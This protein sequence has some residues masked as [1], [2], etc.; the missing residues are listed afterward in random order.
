M[1]LAAAMVLAAAV[2]AA[3]LA[4]RWRA[5]LAVGVGALVVAAAVDAA[6]VWDGTA[7]PGGAKVFGLLGPL[8]GMALWS[9][10]WRCCSGR[11]ATGWP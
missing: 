9:A 6:G 10:G 1:R 4:W 2:V 11:R 7:E 5:V 8:V 3:A